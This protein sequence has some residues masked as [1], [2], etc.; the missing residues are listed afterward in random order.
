M[1]LTKEQEELLGE[2][3]ELGIDATWYF[4]NE[5]PADIDE[6]MEYLEER[7]GEIEVIYYNRAI[8]YLAEND[9]SLQYSMEIAHEYG[10][11]TDKLNSEL[12][13]TLLKQREAS[14]KLEEYRD[15]IEELFF[16]KSN[17]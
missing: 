10:Y 13:A 1:E 3:D 11:T 8:E 5:A 14:E 7:V 6:C 2:I 16:M 4:K 12:L 17:V 9:P 15:Q